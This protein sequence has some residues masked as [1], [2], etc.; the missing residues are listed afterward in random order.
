MGEHYPEPWSVAIYSERP[1]HAKRVLKNL[2]TED[3]GIPLER[4]FYEERIV[5]P[6]T[7]EQELK[8]V[9]P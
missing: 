8:G 9:E 5:A 2:I 1:E 7:A 3:L 4:Q 6:D